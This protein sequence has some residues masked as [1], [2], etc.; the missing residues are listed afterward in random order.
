MLQASTNGQVRIR[1]TPGATLEPQVGIK[2]NGSRLTVDRYPVECYP[3]EQ[4]HIHAGDIRLPSERLAYHTNLK[5]ALPLQPFVYQ[6]IILC[7]FSPPDSYQS[8]F[9]RICNSDVVIRYKYGSRIRLP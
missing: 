3:V 9:K 1:E 8:E 4:V 6:N 5:N 2:T 7:T